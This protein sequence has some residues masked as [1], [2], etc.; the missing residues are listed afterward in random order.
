MGKQKR[1]DFPEVWRKRS[2]PGT[3]AGQDPG[4]DIQDGGKQILS[5]TKKRNSYG[6]PDK[7]TA[8]E[9]LIRMFW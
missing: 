3:V 8:A 6:Y 7:A 9:G 1:R 4:H 5:F 2:R